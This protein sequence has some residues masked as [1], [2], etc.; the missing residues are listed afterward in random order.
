MPLGNESNHSMDGLT[1]RG[2]LAV[3]NNSGGIAS[4]DFDRF[5]AL[6]RQAVVMRAQ[7]Y[8]AETYPRAASLVANGVTS[9]TLYAM[10]VGLIAGDVVANMTIGV[11]T[12]GT[13]T[14]AKLGLYSKTGNT[15]LCSS[16]DASVAFGSTGPKT[17]AMT[18]PYTVVADDIYYVGFLAVHTSLQCYRGSTSTVTTFSGGV[19]NGFAM[20]MAQG[21]QVDLPATA[22]LAVSTSGISW[23]VAIS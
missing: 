13:M 5:A 4:V 1:V 7:G 12:L 18:T 10:A 20:Q 9:G 19:G 3:A 22:T 17:L 8:Y 14:L 15:L 16:A 23:W 11:S 2:G 6:A 21:S